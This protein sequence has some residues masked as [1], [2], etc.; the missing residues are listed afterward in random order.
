MDLLDWLGTL[1]VSFVIIVIFW[2]IGKSIEYT[3]ENW[4]ASLTKKTAT[5]LD[6]RIVDKAKKPLHYLILFIGFY[7]ALTRLPLEGSINSI[8]DGVI[9]IKGCPYTGK[10]SHLLQ[11]YRQQ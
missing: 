3:L 7:I 1:F 8:I 5:D 9:F 10:E 4:V 11:F 2:A 6:D